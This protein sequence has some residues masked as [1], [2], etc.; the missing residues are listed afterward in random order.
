MIQI[1]HG[2]EYREDV[3]YTHTHTH[4]TLGKVL[5]ERDSYLFVFTY[6]CGLFHLYIDL[7]VL[8]Q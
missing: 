2:Q 7:H 6:K 4:K 1:L 8:Y 3:F 5:R